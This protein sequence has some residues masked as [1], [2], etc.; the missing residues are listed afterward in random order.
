MIDVDEYEEVTDGTFSTD[1]YVKA[2]YTRII[3]T[4]M[5]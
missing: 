1:Y 3:N 2:E 5:T 4:N